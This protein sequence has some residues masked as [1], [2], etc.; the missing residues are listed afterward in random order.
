[1]IHLRSR[2]KIRQKMATNLTH[3]FTRD[4]AHLTK[5]LMIPLRARDNV[6]G[7]LVV[8]ANLAETGQANT[9]DDQVC[10]LAPTE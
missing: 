5:L 10:A 1:M 6:Q 7:R 4:N 3:D 9:T 2:G 8:P